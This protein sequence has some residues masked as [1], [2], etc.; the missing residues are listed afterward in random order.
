MGFLMR[1]NFNNQ[2]EKKGPSMFRIVIIGII[3]MA[4]TLLIIAINVLP[5]RLEEGDTVYKAEYPVQTE[6]PT[7][8]LSSQLINDVNQFAATSVP[9]TLGVKQGNR[10]Y[11]PVSLYSSLLMLSELGAG[12]T[13][14]EILAAL[15]N[16]INVDGQATQ[17]F[18]SLYYQGNQGGLVL[19]NSLWINTS[20]EVNKEYLQQ[21]GEQNYLTSYQIGFR[22]GSSPDKVGRWLRFNSNNRLGARSAA[23]SFS[24]DQYFSLVGSLYYQAQWQ[25]PFK[26]EESFTTSFGDNE[27][28]YMKKTEVGS[29]WQD[30]NYKL[31]SMELTDGN[32]MVFV[33]PEENTTIEQLLSDS[34]LVDKVCM[35]MAVNRVAYNTINWTV[36]K[37]TLMYEWDLIDCFKALGVEKAFT[38]DADFST[39]TSNSPVNFGGGRQSVIISVDE[40]GCESTNLTLNTT[41]QDLYE[42]SG[43]TAT[44]ELTKPFIVMVLGTDNLPLY[45]G[46]VENPIYY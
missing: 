27:V 25:K 40:N 33:L 10:L 6:Q 2:Y 28:T 34:T 20:I 23:Y 31:G 37:F 36:P 30:D 9:K 5:D 4:I 43:E 44:M 46:V 17:L 1:Q 35:G 15:N 42:P 3:I 8:E 32:K 26:P 12:E 14:S 24:N 19:G 11:S 13:N 16:Q 18:S 45:I 21:I 41:G 22:S 38:I 29:Y 39:V 7:V